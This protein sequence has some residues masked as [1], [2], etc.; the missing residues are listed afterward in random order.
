MILPVQNFSTFS[1]V[2]LIMDLFLPGNY[3][4]IGT[5]EVSTDGGATW[6]VVSTLTSNAAWQ[7]D[8]TIPLNAYAGQ[9]NVLVSIMYDD[10][11]GWADAMGVDDVRLEQVAAGVDME[12]TAADVYDYTIV[13][14]S[15]V[16]PI[17]LTADVTNTGTLPAADASLTVNVYQAPNLTTPIQT[18][19]SGPAA[20]AAGATSNL[21]A[22]TFTPSAEATYLLEFITTA[23]GDANTLN[24]TT[25]YAFVVSG[26]E[27]ARDDANVVF[28]AG[29][30]AGPVG[31]LGSMFDIVTPTA[32][33]SVLAAFNK[34][35]TDAVAGD[36]VGDST[37]YFVYSVAAGLPSAII[38][39]SDAYVFTPAD[40]NGL[41]VRTL[42]I[43]ATGGGPLNLTPG[44]YFVAAGEYNTNV[45]LAFTDNNFRLNTHY[46]SWPAQPWT[47]AEN[48]PVQFQRAPVIR[49]ILGCA[50]TATSSSTDATCTAADGSAT[51]VPSGTAPYTITWSTGDTTTSINFVTAGTYTYTIID[52][53]GCDYTD[54]VVVGSNSIAITGTT[55]A[56][57]ATC[58]NA[59]G[60]ATATPSNGTAPYTYLWSDGQTTATATGLAAAAYTVTVTDANGCTG[61]LNVTVN[62]AG[63][64]SVAVTSTTDVN[65][66]GGTDG[67]ID[68]TVTGGTAPYTYS[69]TNG[70]TTE[71]LT[72]LGAGSYTG[73]ITDANG[74]TAIGGPITINEPADTIAISAVVTDVTNAGGSDGAIDITV[75]GGTSPY[76]YSWSNGSTSGDL[77]GLTA[78]TYDITVTD[79]NGCTETLSV[80]VMDGTNSLASLN[81]NIGTL[82][83]YPNPANQQVTLELELTQ[84]SNVNVEVT[85]L[86]GQVLTAQSFNEV[87]ETQVVLNIEDW[88]RGVYLV[89]IQ[90]ETGADIV[91]F[92]KQ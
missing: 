46:F 13:P 12:L 78:G 65:C 18:T 39:E 70:A 91:R 36:G 50:L 23:T 35:G 79:A 74:C 40:T 42:E 24:D 47:P 8:V 83:L 62:N 51:I 3:G 27:Y 80:E 28:S 88:A 37:R 26:D 73:T 86:N 90:T 64:P 4:G 19:T 56:T 61:T 20:V 31:Y 22:T 11:G 33:D 34:P 69:W 1:G 30:G 67:A 45:G 49:P 21:S 72:G 59:D 81:A 54:S 63:A 38:G 55:V 58:G 5:V 92:V 43:Q 68:I 32:I 16:T 9:T 7:N 85:N 76:T 60:T 75:S 57:D 77:T 25:A 82:N 10:A 2:N 6:T 14:L 84:V 48:F 52:G 66:N 15:Q 89:K 44:T 17:A 29:I 53:S 41:I 71:D 87:S